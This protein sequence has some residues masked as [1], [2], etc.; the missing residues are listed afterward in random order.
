MK[1]ITSFSGKEVLFIAIVCSLFFSAITWYLVDTYNTKKELS[2]NAKDI[3]N[4]YN[5]IVKNYYEEVD[6]NELKNAAVNGMISLL[7]EKYSIFINDHNSELISSKL[8]G[9]YKGI[10]ITMVKSKNNKFYVYSVVPNSYADKSGL[11]VG[12]EVLTINGNVLSEKD[13]LEDIVNLIKESKFVR[14]EVERKGEL[15]IFDVDVGDVVI[16]VVGSEVFLN[17][18]YNIGYIGI[19]SFTEHAYE[20]FVTNLISIEKEDIKGLII[21]LRGNSGG[22]LIEA[23]KI[24]SK[25]IIKGKPL[26]SLEGKESKDTIYDETDEYRTY[27]I[28]ILVNEYSASASE[29]LALALRDNYGAI[30]VGTTTYGKGKVQQTEKLSDDSMIKYTSAYWY[31]PN[32][33]NIDGKGIKPGIT[34]ELEPDYYK[35]LESKDDNQL[36]SGMNVI[37]NILSR[38]SR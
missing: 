18:N 10:G 28:V 31:S 21:D 29:I 34:I 17:D 7:D 33:I 32:G 30:L 36:R 13:E 1:K 35:S 5:D 14:F 2:N 22:Y 24:A 6:E 16:P 12:D 3:L 19:S 38:R 25:F 8:D 11:K 4:T 37:Y 26:V 9:S 15:K 20:Q 23:T 27:P